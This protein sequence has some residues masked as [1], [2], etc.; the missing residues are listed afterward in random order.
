MNATYEVATLREKVLR[1]KR[2]IATNYNWE[3]I[4]TNRVDELARIE[5]RE[6]RIAEV[7]YTENGLTAIERFAFPTN[8]VT[9][10]DGRTEIF[11]N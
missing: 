6:R 7:V 1:E 11:K 5:K 3:S 4:A 9:Y 2:H 10:V 8:R